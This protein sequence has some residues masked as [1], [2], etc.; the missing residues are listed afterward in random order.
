MFLLVLIYF[1]P[2]LPWFML[3]IKHWLGNM[4]KKSSQTTT[5]PKCK[6][7]Y[8]RG[9]KNEFVRPKGMKPKGMGKS[10]DEDK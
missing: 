6:N 1:S 2:S 8:V 10:L 9:N 3:K 4:V 7:D 5:G